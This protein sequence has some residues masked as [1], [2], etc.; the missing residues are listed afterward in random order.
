MK[1]NKG[2]KTS[3]VFFLLYALLLFSGTADAQV[4][5]DVYNVKLNNV[6]FKEAMV[7][8]TSQS[9]YFFVYEDADIANIPKISKEFKSSTINQIM[10]DCVKG[11]G[12]TFSIDKKV[13]YIKI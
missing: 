12:L 6:T 2:Y 5:K 4:Q 9:G 10:D 13:I 11:T 7:Q 8:I 3:F 1:K